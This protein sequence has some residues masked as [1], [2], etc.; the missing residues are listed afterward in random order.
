MITQYRVE[1]RRLLHRRILFVFAIVAVIALFLVGL[2]IWSSSGPEEHYG[3][4][5]S[6]YDPNTGEYVQDPQVETLNRTF[7][8]TGLVTSAREVPEATADF[9]YGSGRCFAVTPSNIEHSPATWQGVPSLY[10]PWNGSIAYFTIAM[11][12]VLWIIAATF[13]GEEFRHG[14]VE[15]AL[16]AEPRRVRLL[17]LRLASVVTVGVLVYLISV[18]GFLLANVPA[19]V[20]RGVDDASVSPVAILASVGRGLLAV[21]LVVALSASIAVIGRGT[22]LP[23]GV[24]LGLGVLAGGFFLFI[25][26]LVPVEFFTNLFGLVT[27]G[28]GMRFHTVSQGFDG[29][30]GGPL[31]SVPGGGWPWPATVAVVGAYAI[32][33]MVGAFALFTRRDVR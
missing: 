3:S 12:V 16:V 4:G 15:T 20:M 23:L 22:L 11:L 24:L 10:E 1:L 31:M 28:D 9:F 6:T 14:T 18:V 8:P 21:V 27:G 32:V 29:Q 5:I 2:G 19:W 25:H 13:V 30:A 17:S 26:P 33:A 7:C